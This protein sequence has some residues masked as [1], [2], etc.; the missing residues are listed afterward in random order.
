MYAIVCGKKLHL[1]INLSF[2]FLVR[3][4]TAKP[5]YQVPTD[6]VSEPEES[7]DEGYSSPEKEE[8]Y[9]GHKHGKQG[10][11]TSEAYALLGQ[12]HPNSNV[13]PTVN[14][15]ASSSSQRLVLDHM[16]ETTDRIP[17]CNLDGH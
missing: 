5:S 10:F 8:I 9:K 17:S 11:V 4:P 1:F 2:I 12:K 3:P 6:P 13:A 7:S 16:K 15:V 14:P